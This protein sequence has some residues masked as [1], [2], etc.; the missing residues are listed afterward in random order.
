MSEEKIDFDEE[1]LH[2]VVLR[3]V[4]ELEAKFKAYEASH[5]LNFAG[6]LCGTLAKEMLV[7]M[8]FTSP[9][10]YSAQKCWMQIIESAI[11]SV[12]DNAMYQLLMKRFGKKDMGNN[13]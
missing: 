12:G 7:R 3:E 2:K 6:S 4:T 5:G 9:D 8:V 1:E 10:M 11:Q 13:T